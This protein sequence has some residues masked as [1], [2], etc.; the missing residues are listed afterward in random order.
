VSPNAK[1]DDRLAPILHRKRAESFAQYSN[2]LR[3]EPDGP[4][5]ID[6][7]FRLESSMSMPVDQSAK[8]SSPRIASM[9]QF[10]GFTILSMFAVH[11][12]GHLR[13][14]VDLRPILGHNN[15]FLSYA[16][17]VLPAFLF[18][19]G[20]SM[21]LSLLKR[22]KAVGTAA[23][24]GRVIRRCILLILILQV[25]MFDRWWPHFQEVAQSS[26]ILSAVNVVAKGRMWDSLS[27]IGFT[28]LWVLP[29]LAAATRARVIFVV[30]GLVVHAA[31]CQVFYSNYLYGL[32]NWVDSWFGTTGELG[33]EGG[34][35]GILTWAVP[36]IAGT[37][38]Y[39]LVMA[40]D[41]IKTIRV[42]LAGS[43]VLISVGYLLSC[44]ATLYP[45][46]DPATTAEYEIIERHQVADSPVLPPL[47]E[48]AQ[49][50]LQLQFATPPLV[51]PPA[52]RQR[53]LNYWIMTKRVVT[54]TFVITA[55]GFCLLGYLIFVLVSD[56]GGRQLGVLRTFGQN[57]LA[58]YILELFILNSALRTAFGAIRR[59]APTLL[60]EE[61]SWQF[62]LLY[63]LVWF[64]VTYLVV[65]WLERRR[66]YLRL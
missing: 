19:S 41:R 61:E 60:P 1:A 55:T 5:S 23:A 21:R 66:W 42:L 53:Q 36:M 50:G 10:R 65:R 64:A 20:F 28:S 6:A 3:E 11:Y 57:P 26:G 4:Y 37:L 52:D 30:T 18:A 14:L 62:G 27:I 25:L 49:H 51:R 24:Y 44:V 7:P 9:D 45:R 15:T 39:D 58:A 38:V 63:C 17:V 46:V 43:V 8:S 47:Q 35:L 22:I 54:P 32:P 40:G 13:S 2:L 56:V 48:Q 59:C 12:G 31:L 16:D 29:V 33:Y 34:L